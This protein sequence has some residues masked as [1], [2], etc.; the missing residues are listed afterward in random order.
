ML[1]RRLQRRNKRLVDWH[2]PRTKVFVTALKK[3]LTVK[4]LDK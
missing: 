4:Q 2:L 3:I 1:Q